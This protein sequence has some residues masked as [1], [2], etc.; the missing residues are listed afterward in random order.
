LL[1]L[2]G[3]L[4][5]LEYL[6]M[7][8]REQNFIDKRVPLYYQLE[9]LL[10]ER[11]ISGEFK[12]GQKIPTEMELIKQYGVSRMTVRQALQTLTNEGLIERKQGRGTIVAK[13]KTKYRKFSNVVHLS[14]SLDELIKMGMETSVKVLEMN[15]VVADKYEADFLQIKPGTKVY[16]LKRLRICEGEPFGL[17]VNYLPEEIGSALTIS[18]LSSGAILSIIENKLGY[19]LE[20]ATQE[21]RAELADAYVAKVLE[22]PVG[23]ALLS[24]E[25]VVYTD[26]DKPVEYVHS[27]YR[28]DL[29]GY[30]VHLVRER[31][32]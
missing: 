14:G 13:R 7:P 16:R 2:I 12:P 4:L 8:R 25:R 26:K 29:Y 3:K 6:R 21:I 5:K 22:I 20:R 1:L 32:S 23:T 10:R 11:I 24:I 31:K 18:E 19:R 9:N 17:I 15:K 30:S 27:L 28:S